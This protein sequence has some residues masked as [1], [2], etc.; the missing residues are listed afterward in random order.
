MISVHTGYEDFTK[1][2]MKLRIR[3]NSIRYRLTKTEV[4]SFCENGFYEEET[5]FHQN[6]FRYSLYATDQVQELRASCDKNII[7]LEVPLAFTINWAQNEE[8][9]ISAI[10]LL[11]DGS[12]L[13]LLLEKDFV[14]LDETFEDQSDNYP[15]PRAL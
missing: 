8:V 15:N 3:G 9:G 2:N 11:E 1:D 5:R 14:C 7:K 12:E 4:L 6:I 10:Q 13:F